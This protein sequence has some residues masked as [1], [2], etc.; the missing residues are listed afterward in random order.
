MVLN[1]VVNFLFVQKTP[2]SKINF[3]K[4]FFK[5]F[6]SKKVFFIYKLNFREL[7][8]GPR[9]GI[10]GS[11]SLT[12]VDEAENL[13]KL[14]EFL[15]I[16][17]QKNASRGNNFLIWYDPFTLPQK[18]NENVP[19]VYNLLNK[20]GYKLKSPYCFV[21]KLRWKKSPSE[22]YLMNR[23]GEIASAGLI[24]TMK[25]TRPGVEENFLIAKMDFECRI[26]GAERLAYPPVVAGGE[27]A[28]IIHYLNA[29][30][31]IF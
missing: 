18:F 28:N 26:R 29:D 27:R 3:S 10:E 6:V 22:I 31:V 23:A 11:V 4:F 9:A 20:T 8:E 30:Q 13:D 19:K 5:N 7:W 25:F 14:E 24:E 16:N 17:Y 1:V 12:G 15:I 2:T 21:H